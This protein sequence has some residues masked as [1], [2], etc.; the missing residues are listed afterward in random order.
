MWSS[1]FG[2]REVRRARGGEGGGY[3]GLSVYIY[4]NIKINSLLCAGLRV[5]GGGGE[6]GRGECYIRRLRG[7]LLDGRDRG[8]GE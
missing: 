1:W 5:G 7:F 2:H 3:V 4:I 6:R 8:W